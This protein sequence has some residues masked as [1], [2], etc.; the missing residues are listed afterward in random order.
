MR[1]GDLC[2][3]AQNDGGAPCPLINR[4]ITEVPYDELCGAS[5]RGGEHRSGSFQ[6]HPTA[7]GSLPGS[8]GPANNPQSPERRPPQ[9]AN[10]HGGLIRDPKPGSEEILEYESFATANGCDMITTTNLYR[11][12]NMTGAGQAVQDTSSLQG[13]NLDQ[14]AES[15]LSSS[16]PAFKP[17]RPVASNGQLLRAPEPHGES[18]DQYIQFVMAHGAH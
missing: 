4:T 18:L 16:A 8:S 2:T 12:V 13:K 7:V 17:Q 5:S 1:P 3:W 14:S 10:R 9:P 11:Q 15:V 6:R